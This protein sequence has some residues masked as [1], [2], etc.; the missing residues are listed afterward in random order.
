MCPGLV[1]VETLCFRLCDGFVMLLDHEGNGLNLEKTHKLPLKN[2]GY[3]YNP[4]FSSYI[5]GQMRT[6]FSNKEALNEKVTKTHPRFLSK[7]LDCL[8]SCHLLAFSSF[9]CSFLTYTPMKFN[10]SPLKTGG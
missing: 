2:K 10:S 5:T 7:V 8:S 3:I 4:S 6:I 9:L 1:E